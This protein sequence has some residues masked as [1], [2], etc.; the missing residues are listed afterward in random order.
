RPGERLREYDVGPPGRLDLVFL[1]ER[2]HRV[3]PGQYLHEL[4]ALERAWR[5]RVSQLLGKGL[6]AQPDAL[7]GHQLGAVLVH[8][9]AVFDALHAGGN[10]ALDRLG[11]VGVDG[12]VGAPV[13]SGVDGGT[14]LGLGER[15]RVERTVR[16]GHAPAG[17]EL[18]L[19]G[20]LHELLARSN[21][22]FIG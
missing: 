13:A 14:Q 17:G 20:A 21:A 10:G 7:L 15:R 5:K 4:L 18:D 12:D 3:G 9:V 16:R 8:Q 22:D 1:G 2:D 19:R 6:R 11:N